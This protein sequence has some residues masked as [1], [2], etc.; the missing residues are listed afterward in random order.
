MY[1]ALLFLGVWLQYGNTLKH[2]YVWDDAIVITENERVQEGLAGIKDLFRYYRSDEL[3]DQ[4]GYRP[5]TLLSFATDISLFGMN[6]HSA[7]GMNVFYFSLVCIALFFMLTTLFPRQN[8]IFPFLVTLLFLVHP[9]HVEVVANIKSRDEILALLFSLLS[10]IFFLQFFRKGK[11]YALMLSLISFGLAFLS[12]E[13]AFTILLVIPVILLLE[14]SVSLKKRLIFLLPVAG[15]MVLALIAVAV[16]GSSTL[17]VEV[18]EGTGSFVESN[19][20]GNPLAAPHLN[21]HRYATSLLVL[22]KYIKNFLLPYPLVYFYGFNQIPITNWGNPWVYLSLI[23]HLGLVALAVWRFRKN[24]YLSLGIAWYLLTITIYSNAIKILADLMADRFLFMPSVGLCIAFV[25]GLSWALGLNMEQLDVQK[26]KGKTNKKAKAGK[27]KKKALEPTLVS[28]LQQEVLAPFQ[29][30][31]GTTFL[32]IT[33]ILVVTCFWLTFN[34]N[35]AWKDNFTLY[36]TDMEQLEECA[37]AHY[38]YATELALQLD[39]DPNNPQLRAD[40]ERHFKRSIEIHPQSFYSFISLGRIYSAWGE[41]DKGIQLFTQA[42]EQFP[43]EAQPYFELGKCY[44]FAGRLVEAQEPLK[45][46]TDLAPNLTEA[47]FFRSMAVFHAGAQQSGLDLIDQ[48]IAEFPEAVYL[49]NAQ[50]D[51]RIIMGDTV[52]GIESLKSILKYDPDF[53]AAYSKIVDR[54]QEYGRQDSAQKYYNEAI[55]RGVWSP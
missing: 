27:S 55:Y 30:A 22:G 15:M 34:R 52:S 2:D 16:A 42:R 9:V 54:Y 7:H 41:Y 48:T 1:C 28:R 37:R 32:A 47:Y 6:P 49:Y 25:A 20:L 17:G 21:V 33:G 24:P 45:V 19:V 35:Q 38:Y 39:N 50:S 31:K 43:Q 5:I 3:Q 4:Y 44:F 51:F 46:A 10:I 40:V 36:S 11:W 53:G 18:T 13:N 29:G 26:G 12:K 8:T 23:L 14:R